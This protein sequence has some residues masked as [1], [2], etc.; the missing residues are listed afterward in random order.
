MQINNSPGYPKLSIGIERAKAMQWIVRKG[1]SYVLDPNLRK[2]F[3]KN[4]VWKDIDAVKP[5]NNGA[6]TFCKIDPDILHLNAFI[7]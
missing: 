1:D 3:P 4:V 7:N 6:G 2:E 5:V